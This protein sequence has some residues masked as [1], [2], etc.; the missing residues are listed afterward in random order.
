MLQ[1]IFTV[2]IVIVFLAVSLFIPDFSFSFDIS[3]VLNVVALFFTIL[4]GFF[5]AAA[6]SNYLRLKSLV[7][8]ANG[9]FISVFSLAKL[10]DSTGIER[11]A[12]TIDQYMIAILDYDLL[13]YVDKTRKEFHTV[14]EALDEVT[15]QDSKGNALLSQLHSQKTRLFEIHQEIALA[16][17]RVVSR[18]HWLILIFLSLIIAIFLLS[19]RNGDWVFSLIVGVI[20]FAIYR[21]LMLLYEIDSNLLLAKELSYENPQQVFEE[22]GKLPY[23]PEQAFSDQRAKRPRGAYRVGLY[24]NYP[25]SLEKEIRTIKD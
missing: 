23:Y 4:I 17:Q 1:R 7:S 25:S 15:P 10:I 12:N 11:V 19:L 3:T 21:T 22:I 6:T 13:N 16:V 9:G 5:I 2:A 18:N 8:Q 20:L 14:M 24:K